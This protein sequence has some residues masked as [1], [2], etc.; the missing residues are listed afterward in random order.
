ML[1][2]RLRIAVPNKGRL[3]SP[4]LKLLEESGIDP[5]Y[6]PS[7]RSLV[8]PTNIDGV[9]IVYARAED[10]PGVVAAGAADLGITGHDLVL[11]S[12]EDVEEL[13]DLQFGRAKLVVAVPETSG[14]RSI[15]DVRPGTRVATKFAR[16]TD[17]FFRG[18]GIRV[19]IVRISGAAE[20]MPI[21]GAADAIVDVMSTGTTLALHGLRP[22]HTILE[23]SARLIGGP[24]RES[25]R[26]LAE[27]VVESLR[28]VIM[29]RRRKL[30]LMNVPD[31]NL[32]DVLSILPSMSG[33]MVAKVQSERPMWEV[34]AA[35]PLDQVPSLVVE[36]RRRGARDIVALGIER[37]M[38]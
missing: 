31:E 30:L 36:L 1:E 32:K 26:D 27:W 35:V 37:L 17:E 11:E 28:S 34:M 25:K 2:G 38:P 19:E 21:L 16:L 33:P 5:I 9:Y 23:S 6:D 22:I 20:V 14:V 18:A 12:G 8:T 10:I 24:S 7:S 15:G 3:R 13:L 4:A 29:A